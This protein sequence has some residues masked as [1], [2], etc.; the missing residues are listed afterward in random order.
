MLEDLISLN[1]AS[2]SEQDELDIHCSCRE[3]FQIIKKKK[4]IQFAITQLEK[5]PELSARN[6]IVSS[7]LCKHF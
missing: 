4:N 6:L 2:V 3:L 5:E 7:F 1:A